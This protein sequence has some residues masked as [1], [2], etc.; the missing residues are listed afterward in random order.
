[1]QRRTFIQ[2][3]AALSVVGSSRLTAAAPRI[4]VIVNPKNAVGRLGA[5]ELEAIFTTR[6]LDWP[7]GK[8]VVA[9]NFPAR[10]A[11]R[12]EFDRLAL[13]LEPDEVGRFWIDRR[14]RGGHP[15]PRQIPDTRTMLRV[16]ASLDTAIG[17][18]HRDEA[19]A[20]VRVV[21]EL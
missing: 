17:Y 6:K 5:G 11:T 1:M 16:V 19:D 21:A 7:S 12:A 13:H 9:Y 15:P 20:S 14:I 4:V 2:V 8:R 10:H 3:V 18:V